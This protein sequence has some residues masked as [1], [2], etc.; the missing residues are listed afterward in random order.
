MVRRSVVW[1]ERYRLMES[2]FCAFPIPVIE[3]GGIS[4]RGVCFDKLGV[5]LQSFAGSKLGLGIGLTWRCEPPV[6]QHDVRV[7]QTGV[8]LG[9]AGVLVDRFLE[10][11]DSLAQAGFGSP[12]PVISSF[13]IIF[14][15]ADWDRPIGTQL[16]ALFRCEMADLLSNVADDVALQAKDIAQIAIVA[17]GP[18]MLVGGAVNQLRADSHAVA[19]PFHGAFHNGIYVEFLRD[20]RYSFV[21]ALV[22][23]D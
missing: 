15:G 17:L 7:G 6:S 4:K 1:I 23:C 2:F 20:H 10:M 16:A 19:G 11:F 21:G 14:V 22:A 12:V 5:E 18:E 8:G 9:I 13:Q 3:Q